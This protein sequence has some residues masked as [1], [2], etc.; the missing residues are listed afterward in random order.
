[1][2]AITRA[3]LL[4]IEYPDHLSK[5]QIA[6]IEDFDCATLP[7]VKRWT[8]RASVSCSS[9]L[10]NMQVLLIVAGRKIRGANAVRYKVNS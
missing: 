4:S 1:M 7:A 2:I 9:A 3:E 8:V 5:A 10:R 6:E